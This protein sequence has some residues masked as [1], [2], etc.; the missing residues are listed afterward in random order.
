MEGSSRPWLPKDTT[1]AALG[2]RYLY[3]NANTQT[4]GND[5]VPWPNKQIRFCYESDDTRTKYKKDLKAA[6]EMWVTKGL[7]KDFSFIEV[8]QTV[9]KEDRANVLLIRDATSLATYP[10]FPPSLPRSGK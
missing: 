9:C 7:G 10:G 6:H 5:K 2:R 3:A 1:I 8:S 4:P